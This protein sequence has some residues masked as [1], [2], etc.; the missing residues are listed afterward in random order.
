MTLRKSIH[1]LGVAL[2][3]LN[4]ALLIFS[5]AQAQG[6]RTFTGD[7]END[8][9][10][11]ERYLDRGGAG[12]VG[13]PNAAPDGVTVG[14]DF[15]D[16]GV[17]YDPGTD[18]LYIGTNM[19]NNAISGDADGDGDPGGTAAWLAG[20][21][22][23]DFADLANDESIDILI[24]ID[25]SCELG[26]STA[27]DY[28]FVAGV[29]INGDTGAFAVREFS[30][31]AADFTRPGAG[32]V[33]NT[34]SG[35]LFASPSPAQPDLEFTIENFCTEILGSCASGPEPVNFAFRARAGS[36]SDD[37]VGEDAVAC[38]KVGFTELAIGLQGVTAPAE[39]RAPWP[40]MAFLLLALTGTTV[41]LR[42]RTR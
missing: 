28:E 26:N 21:Q 9:F 34:Y 13:V 8:F 24:D 3:F 20:L 30:G 4:G 36:G 23:A 42:F 41:W 5:P 33:G 35:A 14:W 2:L 39:A 22:G 16:V 40:L 38:T 15:L 32:Y 18:T 29:P 10:E 1:L 37:G 17:A 11:D 7:V 6:A 31:Q 19:A 25:Q 12:D 27:A